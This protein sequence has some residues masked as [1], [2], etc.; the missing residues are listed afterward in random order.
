M[1]LRAM[2]RFWDETSNFSESECVTADTLEALKNQQ[3]VE[4]VND[5][6]RLDWASGDPQSCV[7]YFIAPRKNLN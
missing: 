5:L 4:L 7:H 2:C 3:P 1:H 6:S